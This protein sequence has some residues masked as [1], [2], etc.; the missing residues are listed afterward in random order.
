M[1]ELDNEIIDVMKKIK[2][3]LEES[4]FE[5]NRFQIAGTGAKGTYLTLDLRRHKEDET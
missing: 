2:D 1:I 5:V 4:V 3:A